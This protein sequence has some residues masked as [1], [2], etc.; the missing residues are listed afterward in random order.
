MI[1][2][3]YM[4]NEIREATNPA[5]RGRKIINQWIH[6]HRNLAGPRSLI[7]R[8]RSY[9]Q[10]SSRTVLYF[11]LHPT[12]VLPRWSVTRCEWVNSVERRGRIWVV[13][14]QM[15]VP[16]RRRGPATTCSWWTRDITRVCGCRRAGEKEIWAPNVGETRDGVSSAHS[17]SLEPL[18][19]DA[20]S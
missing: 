17:L 12:D 1:E 9:L 11:V 18:T 5:G 16:Y 19:L 20:G 15:L 13:G 2:N 3:R 6:E 7:P 8:S 14:V 10:S 4:R